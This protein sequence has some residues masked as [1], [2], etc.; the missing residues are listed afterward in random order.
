MNILGTVTP[1]KSLGIWALGHYPIYWLLSPPYTGF[2]YTGMDY[3]N[4][5]G[6]IRLLPERERERG[7]GKGRGPE[8]NVKKDI[9]EWK[10]EN[11]V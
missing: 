11:M 1:F 9:K 2:F 5:K 3:K 10:K 4:E 6:R 8:E 7:G